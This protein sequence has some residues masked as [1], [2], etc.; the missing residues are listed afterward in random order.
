VDLSHSLGID[1]GCAGY[2]SDYDNNTDGWYDWG[3]RHCA[4]WC[5]WVWRIKDGDSSGMLAT[6]AKKFSLWFNHEACNVVLHYGHVINYV[7]I[8]VW[9]DVWLCFTS[10]MRFVCDSHWSRDYCKGTETQVFLTENPGCYS[11]RGRWA[12]WR[13][14]FLINPNSWSTQ[15]T[16]V[17]SR[18]TWTLT[19]ENSLTYPINPFG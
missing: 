1:F 10:V 16:V 5:L 11:G 6:A 14:R 19:L 8:F 9:C 17:Q 3:M 4:Q 2:E 7:L 15:L 18:S 12:V 13:P